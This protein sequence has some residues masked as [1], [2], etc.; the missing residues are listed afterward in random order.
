MNNPRVFI[1]YSH[2]SP[3]HSERVRDFAWALRANGMDTEES[4]D[5]PR[6]CNEQLSREHSDFVLCVCTAEYKRR[7]EGHVPP[8]K[9]KG[10]YWE[11][12]LLDDDIYD[13]KG[14]RRIIPVLLDDEP[15]TSIVRFLR[16]WAHCRIHQFQLSDPAYEHLVRILTRQSK[17]QKNALG[18]VPT[19]E[20]K[21]STSATEPASRPAPGSPVSPAVDKKL[22]TPAR[23]LKPS[24][25]EGG[26]LVKL[27]RV[28]MLS[29]FAACAALSVATYFINP[30]IGF[31]FLALVVAVVLF[32][33]LG[34]IAQVK[35][36]WGKFS[37]AAAAFIA[38]LIILLHYG[39]PES[40]PV[41]ILGMAY[42]D[43]QP[44]T[45]ASI[46]LLGTSFSDNR[47]DITE[48]NPGR[49]EFRGVPGLGKSVEIQIDVRKPIDCPTYRNKYRL[50]SGEIKIEVSSL[51]PLPPRQALH[52]QINEPEKP[53]MEQFV[54]RHP[55][56]KLLDDAWDAT[57]RGAVPRT[58]GVI[59]W[60]GFGK[61]KLVRQWIWRRFEKQGHPTEDFTDG[62]F[63]WTFQEGKS[64]E[65]FARSLFAFFQPQV[66]SPEKLPPP[67]EWLAALRVAM[68]QQRY[69]LVLDGLELLQDA[70]TQG[71]RQGRL[72]DGYIQQLLAAQTEQ[73]LGRGLCLVSSRLPLT[74]LEEHARNGAYRAIE[75]EQSKFTRDEVRF[76]LRSEG[77]AHCPDKELDELIAV[78]G[79]HPLALKTI[80]KILKQDNGGNAA[81]WKRYDSDVFQ[82][83]PGDA[84]RN[85]LWRIFGWTDRLLEKREPE[86]LV[87]GLIAHFREPA[88]RDW[89]YHLLTPGEI[90]LETDLTKANPPVV[91]P[92]EI[93]LL[94]KEYRATPD[95]SPEEKAA[96]EKLNAALAALP[97][98]QREKVV[99]RLSGKPEGAPPVFTAEE[100]AISG[101]KM[102]GPELR[103]V[104]EA[105]TGLALLRRDG[106]RYSMHNLVREHFQRG[107]QKGDP[108]RTNEIHRC[109]YRLYAAV[110]QPVY[111]PD[112]LQELL[113][114]YE[115]VYHGCKAGLQQE[116]CNEVYS[117]RIQRGRE[118]YSVRQ[119]GAFG[120]DLG[121]VACFFDPPWSRVSRAVREDDQ[122]WLLNQAA[123]WLRALGRLTEA[124]EPMRAGLEMILKQ[125]DWERAAANANNLSELELTLG[126]MAQAVR[127]AAQAVT[128]AD[129]SGDAFLRMIMRTIHADALHQTGCRPEAEALFREA[130]Q[131]QAK[132]QPDYPLLYSVRGFKYCDLLL[133]EAERAA[134]QITCS[135]GHRP[136]LQSCHVV[137]QRADTAL[138][139]VLNGS[140][141][142]LDIA[143]NH[144]TLGRAV[145]YAAILEQSEVGRA[146]S[147]VEL[148][149]AGLRRAGD[150]T[151]L[152]RGLLPRAWRGAMKLFLD[153]ILLHRARLFFRTS[154]Y[155]FRNPDSSPRTAE[156]DLA[157]AEKL[158]NDC[159]YHRR[160]EE[161][162]DAKAAILSR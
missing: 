74:D 25:P 37:G 44:V 120:S 125:K 110:V 148:A 112:T 122:A 82:V 86:R 89:L 139:I 155:P 157:A 72:Q 8:E 138:Q 80:A 132:D 69:I 151:F 114:L 121:A 160:D 126:E 42:V 104:L 56:L 107:L 142:L 76:L 2:D 60:G 88:H 75:L 90:P 10:V 73:R 28:Q 15:G 68:G 55:E 22:K 84:N 31:V 77:V 12:S 99:A 17:V 47:R 124:R 30:V 91:I 146:K 51:P 18:A 64:A 29:F 111:Q 100:L 5:W 43:G 65:Q 101:A 113:P 149:V 137:S 16:G 118:A 79:G 105:L 153:D 41:D 106:D 54:G 92:L 52:I 46:V 38:T 94:V 87:I 66:A 32:G 36:R 23:T 97:Q 48:A 143:L 59:A 130:E 136:P 3:A 116:A 127:H 156:D 20:T 21:K 154:P 58:V 129:R 4:V 95:G 135:G 14:N 19:L 67:P 81:G 34:A 145:L 109:L 13:D 117:A 57:A 39:R 6:L 70:A 26:P 53:L 40:R 115:A 24:A 11:G 49:F 9:G 1:S 159:G 7:I 144:L 27:T 102:D 63:W 134:W 96:L 162:A 78:S 45:K 61:T 62:V 161:L 93:K 71:D 83:P 85:H 147:E 98:R 131:L 33:F 119:L 35:N 108:S 128:Y 133:T 158:I 141:N 123:A 152:P 140:R 150:N 50:G 103:R